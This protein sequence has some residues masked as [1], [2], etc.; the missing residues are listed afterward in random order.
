MILQNISLFSLT[1]RIAQS[2]GSILL[3]WNIK[4]QKMNLVSNYSHKNKK[5]KQKLVIQAVLLLIMAFQG[6]FLM[7]AFQQTKS[8]NFI[9]KIVY[10]FGL[11]I[12]STHFQVQVCLRQATNICLYVNGI[13]QFQTK[14]RNIATNGISGPMFT[15]PLSLIERMN[16]F[17]AYA[18]CPSMLCLP[19]AYIYGLHWM[20]PCKPSII[21]YW[22]IPECGTY[23]N[24]GN[25]IWS[26][27]GKLV[28]FVINHWTWSF[29]LN[30]S[31]LVIC[32][33]QI[34]C[35]LSLRGFIEM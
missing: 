8:Y 19:I 18:Y 25:W 11:V 3:R 13:L 1:V 21:G 14:Y 7:P 35:T 27:S 6:I 31:T 32:G 4:T 34:L 15:R 22:L 20:D 23:W 28:V 29:S 30:V 5:L 24:S 33:I 9:V 16:V 12:F 26:F 17:Y 10:G 2:L